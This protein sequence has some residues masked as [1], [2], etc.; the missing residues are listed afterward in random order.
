M[1]ALIMGLGSIG[2][3]WARILGELDDIELYAFRRRGRRH[4]ISKD[5]QSAVQSDPEGKFNMISSFDW[6]SLK[7]ETFDLAIITSPIHLHMHD[8]SLL[9]ET[10][11]KR[12]L[13]EKPVTDR[14]DP[15]NNSIFQEYINQAGDANSPIV[16]VGYQNRFHPAFNRMKDLI[17]AGTV[18]RV[19]Y[20]RT[21]F[22]EWLPG[23]HPYEDYRLT[24]MARAS[25]GGG[26]ITCLSH[27][28]DLVESLFGEIV[29]HQGMVAKYGSLET[30]VAD[31]VTLL[32]RT[33]GTGEGSIYI[34]SRFDFI[35]WPP[36]HTIDILGEN[37][38]MKF[39]WL[40]G[41]LV[42]KSKTFGFMQ[43]DYSQVTRDFVFK[44]Q[45]QHLMSI[46]QMT[47]ENLEALKSA[48]RV[49]KVASE[50]NNAN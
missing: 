8:F 38:S 37:G 15:V 27:D 30:D 17:T 39:D 32:M 21:E 19:L 16:M 34:D 45:L 25:E 35:S 43:E 1:K 29:Y 40:S 47:L 10:S 46:N 6:G 31:S 26:P 33:E 2:Q 24:H 9:L 28:L 7:R 18:G 13:I 5:L 12:I 36:S 44:S 14:I 22:G 48:W 11:V 20:A 23:M 50:Y 41:D 42:I 49:A 3:R 4:T